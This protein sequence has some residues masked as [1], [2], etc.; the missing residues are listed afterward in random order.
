MSTLKRLLRITAL[1]ASLAMM[2]FALEGRTIKVNDAC[3]EEGGDQNT[4]CIQVTAGCPGVGHGYYDKGCAGKCG[5][6]CDDEQP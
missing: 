5:E 1:G 6:P 2:P 4:C 3:A